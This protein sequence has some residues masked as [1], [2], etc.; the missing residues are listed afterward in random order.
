[1]QYGGAGA[2]A[3]RRTAHHGRCAGGLCIRQHSC[4]GQCA[5]RRGWRGAQWGSWFHF[6]YRCAV[7]P[8]I[9]S[10]SAFEYAMGP[11]IPRDQWEEHFLNA[12]DDWLN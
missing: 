5:R 12:D 9:A 11:A 2:I 7:T 3:Q 10:V 4:P 8:D 6:R 1:M